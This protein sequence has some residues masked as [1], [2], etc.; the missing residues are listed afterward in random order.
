VVPY[1]QLMEAALRWARKFLVLPPQHVRKTKA[2]MASMRRIP[3]TALL[4]REYQTREILNEL[5]DT[6]EAAAAFAE[7]RVPSFKGA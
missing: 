6:R 3:D 1:D 2:L 4:E 5:D 7:H